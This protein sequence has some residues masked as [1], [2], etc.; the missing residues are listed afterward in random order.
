MGIWTDISETTDR[1]TES[2]CKSWANE[3][4]IQATPNRLALWSRSLSLH[5]SEPKHVKWQRG[6]VYVKGKLCTDTEAAVN[7]MQRF[8]LDSPT[9]PRLNLPQ[10]PLKQSTGKELLYSCSLRCF[11][12]HSTSH[13]LLAAELLPRLQLALP[14]A[15]QRCQS[16]LLWAIWTVFT[17]MK[18]FLKLFSPWTL[19]C[20]CWVFSVQ[21]LSGWA[22][23]DWSS[24]S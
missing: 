17:V 19:S 13:S 3:R 11:T 18:K 4:N 16:Q 21:E 14:E 23:C 22:F 8:A 5:S 10:N 6:C 24:A 9:C 2:S 7:Y 15:L 1:E 12:S 20:Q